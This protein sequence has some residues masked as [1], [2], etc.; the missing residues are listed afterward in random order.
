[1]PVGH[2]ELTRAGDRPED[3]ALL[4]AALAEHAAE[5]AVKI[6]QLLQSPEQFRPLAAGLQFIVSAEELEGLLQA[7]NDIRVG[8]WLALGGPD[9]AGEMPA[10][11][12]KNVRHFWA[13]DVAG[14]FQMVF[15]RALADESPAPPEP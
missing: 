15:L 11:D 13:M 2:Q 7:L 5:N 6:R 3:Q 10:V 12:E 9:L 14:N 4:D 8:S 1:M